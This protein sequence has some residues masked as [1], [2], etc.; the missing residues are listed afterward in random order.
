MKKLGVPFRAV[1]SGFR[2]HIDPA[3]FPR[4]VVA[5]LSKGKAQS[6][7]KRFP[8]AIV[9]GA[10]TVV[11]IGKKILGKPRDA[12]EAARMLKL[13]SGRTHSVLTGI[14]IMD[15]RSGK[16]AS[17]V[18]ETK[19]RF[20]KL[21]PRRIRAYIATKEPF[22]KAGAYALQGCGV[23]LIKK[24]EGDFWGAVGLPLAT[25]SKELRKFGVRTFL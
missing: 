24:I 11:A 4:Q 13:L 23:L 14:T 3:L 10:D 6:V 1:A 20:Q 15:V 12:A 17:R 16:S 2:E 8:G 7:A 25:L 19:V 21:T 9:I 5:T 22:G 18:V